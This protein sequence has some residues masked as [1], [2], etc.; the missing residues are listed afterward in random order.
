MNKDILYPKTY[1]TSS[2]SKPISKAKLTAKKV[3]IKSTVEKVVADKPKWKAQIIK[4]LS[5]NSE[6]PGPP[7]LWREVI[8]ELDLEWYPDKFKVVEPSDME[9]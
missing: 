8:E 9:V 2:I 4:E 7:S 1:T 5:K 3:L 6:I